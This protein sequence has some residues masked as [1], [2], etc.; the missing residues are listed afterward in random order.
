MDKE[1]MDL[2]IHTKTSQCGIP[3]ARVNFCSI[4]LNSGHTNI[5]IYTQINYAVP[6]QSSL[7][8]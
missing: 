1:L 7:Y 5:Y 4:H 8:S 6:F 2:V 3:G